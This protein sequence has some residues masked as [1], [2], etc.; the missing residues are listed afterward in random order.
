MNRQNRLSWVTGRRMKM[1][2]IRWHQTAAEAAADVEKPFRPWQGWTLHC[3]ASRLNGEHQ[4]HAVQLWHEKRFNPQLGMG[5]HFLVEEDGTI[6]VGRRWR[7]QKCGA[8]EKGYNCTHIGI[9]LAGWFDHEITIRQGL[10]QVKVPGDI[11]TPAQINSLI[12]LVKQLAATLPWRNGIGDVRFH[13]ESQ[14]SKTCPGTRFH[15]LKPELIVAI[16]RGKPDCI[17]TPMIE[18]NHV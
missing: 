8:H 6:A 1:I 2:K 14:P 4:A 17:I 15:G 13:Y 11:P 10:K 7:G 16:I 9:A 12:Q 3:T 18:R 5:Y